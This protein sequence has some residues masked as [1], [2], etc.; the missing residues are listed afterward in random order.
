MTVVDLKSRI[1]AIAENGAPMN[2]KPAEN[3]HRLK[4]RLFSVDEIRKMPDAE[5]L[6]TGLLFRQTLVLL[7]AAYSSFKSFLVLDWALHIA[8]G[9]TEWMGRAVA[10][11]PVVYIYA[12]GTFGIKQRV[13]AWLAA[14][15]L[16]D[17][18]NIYF[19]PTSVIINDPLAVDALIEAVTTLGVRPVLVI[20]DTVHRNMRGDE[21]KAEDVGAFVAGC[22]RLRTTFEATVIAVHHSGWD[23][24]H[25]RGSSSFPG[26]ADTEIRLER[27]GAS[28]TVECK[29]QK[30]APEFATFAL[31]TFPIAGSLA[32]K[33]FG[34]SAP[35]L[36]P[37]ETKCLTAVQTSTSEKGIT[38]GTVAKESGVPR[39]STYKALTRLESLGYVRKKLER[40][41]ATEAGKLALGPKV[42]PSLNTVQNDADTESKSPH[43]PKGVDC[44]LSV[45][46]EPVKT[47]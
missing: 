19:V 33:P 37:N 38:L 43:A 13:N 25:S 45:G 12:E 9:L 3:G 46:P 31:E 36:T 23:P 20:V 42:Y 17:V 29:K 41:T 32:L 4:V 35:E 8:S 10:H 47:T 39:S 16:E 6:I 11:G 44:G 27:D 30:D 5:P 2:G 22:D 34:L 15:G 21:N 18:G 14:N 40:Y 26:D 28:F 1:T 24:T 7:Y